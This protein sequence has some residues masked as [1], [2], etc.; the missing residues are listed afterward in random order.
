MAGM[1]ITLVSVPGCP[2]ADLARQR[3]GE[4]LWLSGVDASVTE[5]VVARHADAVREGFAGS[6]TVLVDGRD[7]F[8]AAL[9]RPGVACRLYPTGGGVEG[10]P[11]VRALVDVL[12]ANRRVAGTPSFAGLTGPAGDEGSPGAA[13]LAEQVRWAA[14][15]RLVAGHPASPGALAEE[16]GVEV[17]QVRG[18]VEDQAR[19]GL[20][21]VDGDGRVLGAH[22]LTL[23][24]TDHELVVEGVVLHTWCALD[25]IG[26]PAALG[27]GARVTTRSGDGRQV[28]LELHAGEPRDAG[29]AVLWLPTGSCAD[30]R[31]DFCA[32][33]NVFTTPAG[34]DAWRH[35]AGDPPGRILTI[36]EAAELGRAWWTRGTDGCCS[37]PDPAERAPHDRGSDPEQDGVCEH[38]RS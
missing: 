21:D 13:S 16:L 34:L 25:A 32:V 38:C 5:R 10:A 19:R 26:I 23:M 7:P 28:V 15:D 35:R 30:L 1:E 37:T 11:S 22:G 18:V 8:P 14:F 36:S 27:A 3:L 20:V 17:A 12:L 29:D 24:P 9:V 31:A 2:H 6:P 4:A 33:A